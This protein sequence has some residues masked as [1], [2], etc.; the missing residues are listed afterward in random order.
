MD[1]NSCASGLAFSFGDR[2]RAFAV[3]TPS[4]GLILAGE[5]ANDLDFVGD[6]KTRIEADTELTDQRNVILR[7]AA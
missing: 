4:P 7:V 5:T 6:H 2:E 1:G 3:R